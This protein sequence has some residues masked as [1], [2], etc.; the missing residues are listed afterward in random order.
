MTFERT[1]FVTTVTW[2]RT[3]LFRLAQPAE[4]MMDVVAQY[5]EQKKYALHEFV[6]MPDHLH[7]LLTPAPEISLERAMQLIK[8]GFSFRMGKAKRGLVWQ[9]SFTNHRVRDEQDYAYHVEY[10]RMNPV[11]AFLVGRPELYPYSSANSEI[12]ASGRA[13]AS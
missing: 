12:A 6:I 2:Q 7:L 3:P 8:G 5:R 11:R 9:E 4:L 10:I 1:F 13:Q